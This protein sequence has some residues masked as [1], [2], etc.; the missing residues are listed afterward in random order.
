MK[1]S[2][3]ANQPTCLVVSRFRSKS[4]GIKAPRPTGLFCGQ[5][6]GRCG[7]CQRVGESHPPARTASMPR[8]SSRPFRSQIAPIQLP[9]PAWVTNFQSALGASPR[10]W[11]FVLTTMAVPRTRPFYQHKNL[12]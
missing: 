4:D 3:N 9:P 1:H 8:V 2:A 10:K 6:W 7:F 11:T 12:N 5:L